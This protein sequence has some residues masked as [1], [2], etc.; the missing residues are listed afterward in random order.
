VKLRSYQQA[1]IDAVYEHLRN[2]AR[3]AWPEYNTYHAYVCQPNRA[4][5]QVTRIGFYSKGVIYPLIPKIEQVHDDVL[6]GKNIYKGRLGELVN[7]LVDQSARI[8]DQ[9]YKV[10]L[11]SSPDSTDTLKLAV[12]I[13][14]DKRDKAGKVAAFTMGQRY[15]A[16]ND[17]LCVKSTSELESEM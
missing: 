2:A 10:F 11:L 4:F 14:N 5:Q 6:I 15:V 16:S 1:A 17:L 12:G 3:I 9:R 7:R 8:I 13:P